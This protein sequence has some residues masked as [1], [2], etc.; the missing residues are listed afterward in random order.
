MSSHATRIEGKAVLVT[1]AKR[2][3]GQ[4]LVQDAWRRRAG[5]VHA[6]GR[7]PPAHADARVTPSTLD[8]TDE[9]Q[10][11]AAVERVESLDLPVNNAGVGPHE[12]HRERAAPERS[13]TVNPSGPHDVT[14]AI[15]P[16]LTESRGAVVNAAS[17]AARAAVPAPPAYPVWKAASFSL[18]QAQRAPGAGRGVSPHA[19]ILAPVDTD[20]TRGPEIPKF[21]P[22]PSPKASSPA[23]RPGSRRSSRIR[24]Q[25]RWRTAGAAVRPS[26]SSTRTPRSSRHN[27]TRHRQSNT[28]ATAQDPQ[29]LPTEPPQVARASPQGRLEAAPAPAAD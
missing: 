25:R 28:G 13:P 6:A 26:S 29:K 7:Q 23:W 10:I 4:A 14:H 12:D 16:A 11:R 8:V 5:R 27:R 17:L 21:S 15:P 2:G 22:S 9:G 20:T 18:P 1:G 19:A 3:L 24:R